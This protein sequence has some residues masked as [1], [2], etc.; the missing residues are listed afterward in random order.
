MKTRRNILIILGLVLLLG[1]SYA[2]YTYQ[3][4]SGMQNLLNG[5][6]Y[7]NYL[8]DNEVHISGIFPETKE[9]AL[10]RN[11]NTVSFKVLSKNTS[12]KDIYYGITLN[13]GEEI[14]NKIR[15]NAKYVM[16]YLEC[17]GKVLIDG[18][19]YSDFNNRRIYV[20]KIDAKTYTETTK[21]YTLRFWI[22][23]ETT[24]SDTD[25]NAS[26][27]ATEW[28]N[29]YLNFKV[30]VD[31][32]LEMMN[33]PLSMETNDTYVENNKAY[34]IAKISNF[35]NVE[36][37]GKDSNDTMNLKVS[38]TNSD[39]KFSYKDSEGNTVEEKSDTLDLNYL[40][41]KNK[42]VEIQVFV[43]P[44]ND[45]NGKTNVLLEIYK[46]KELMQSFIKRVEVK[47]NNYCLNNGFNKLV[48]CM[49]VSDSLSESV[50]VA[51]TNI[52]NKGE[53]N[54]NDTAPTYTY[55]E[56]IEQNKSNVY[57]TNKNTFYFS[58]S[59]TFNSEFGTYTLTNPII[60]KLS[61]KYI[62]YYTL[63]TTGDAGYQNGNKM[64]K[65]NGVN[66][67]ETE[68]NKI[69]E[70][71]NADVYTYKVFGT[72]QSEVGLYKTVD[73]YGDVYYYRGN[74]QNNNVYFGGYYWKI[75]R[76]NGDNSLRMIYQGKSPTG[77]GTSTSIN[78]TSYQYNTRISDPTYVGYMYGKNFD[79][80]IGNEII[81]DIF[82]ASTKY[83]FSDSYEFDE[84]SEIYKLKGNMKQ[85]TLSEMKDEF[86]T[87]PYTCISTSSTESC[88]ILIKINSFVSETS[89]KVQYYS[90]SSTSLDGTRTNEISNNIKIQLDKWYETNI[91]NN[92]DSDGNLLE[93]YVVDATFC[94]DRSI[95][96]K[97]Y[98]S[99]Y[100][101]DIGTN[102][103]AYSRFA[104]SSSKIP[105]L[106]CSSDMR[107]KFSV[108][109]SRG[110]AKLTYPIAL[111]T[112][113]EVVLAGGRYNLK[114]SDFFLAN[115]VSQWTMTPSF[116]DGI[117]QTSS[118]WNIR[119]DGLLTH[120]SYTTS[121]YAA[122]PVINIRADVLISQGDGT[123][124]NP[125]YL[126][127]K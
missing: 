25:S 65:I 99:G 95:T 122:R 5:E 26:Y 102:Y 82:Q 27:K 10:K 86:E 83:Y 6:I 63:G 127:L 41:T 28:A 88:E 109:S 18:I 107:D 87:Y 113:D 14:S 101:V 20:D 117:Y 30:N 119:P 53:P 125:Y 108:T 22:D 3:K 93:N 77:K 57:I 76:I 103:S 44:N 58:K 23:E 52:S 34:F 112:T 97:T 64:Y 21:N 74:V 73:D 61:D 49:L 40:F 123:T 98:N 29:S 110:N 94:N 116:Y 90:Y 33:M 111:I 66:I 19:R 9:E 71:S 13:Y 72:I 115:G 120:W 104:E 81:Y 105:T 42:I 48:D 24:I 124:N 75:I 17:D 47:G 70:I 36:D 31:A 11:D 4:Y 38:G 16:I 100:R 8:E 56:N 121:S 35:I 118:I 60:D 96:N 126:K 106:K 12:D 7:L 89:A 67:T 84:T 78:N 62:G 80:Q 85:G 92:Y 1:G 37:L 59:Y 46:N 69:S 68:N 114:N 51:K 54:L 39:I 43:H 45:A 32:G 2:F 15:I 79:H 55:V 91:L 50:D